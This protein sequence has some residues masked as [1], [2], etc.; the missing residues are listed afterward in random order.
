[1]SGSLTGPLVRLLRRRKRPKE[2]H[3]L[4]I[5]EDHPDVREA[6]VALLQQE[7]ALTVCGVAASAEEALVRIPEAKPDLVLV[8]VSLP[9]M[10][11]LDLIAALRAH[12]PSLRALVVSGLDRADFGQRAGEV[13]AV[14]YVV[15]ADGPEALLAAIRRALPT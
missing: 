3:R 2:G 15:K 7:P 4:F 9:G 11:G 14:G 6:Y 1:M 8:D 5:V 12:D 13:G 10:S